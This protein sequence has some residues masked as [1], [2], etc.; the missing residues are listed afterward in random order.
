MQMKNIFLFDLLLF[1]H[2]MHDTSG[3][4]IILLLPSAAQ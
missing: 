3:E 2:Q 1:C 4:G